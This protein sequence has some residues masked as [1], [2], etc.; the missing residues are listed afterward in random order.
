MISVGI[1]LYN[2][3][4]LLI[5][6]LVRSAIENG[7]TK[8]YL[9]DNFSKTKKIKIKSMYE[10]HSLGFNSG[11]G[12]GHNY[13]QNLSKKFH[14]Y[15]FV[16]NPDIVIISPDIFKK[17]SKELRINER[18][19]IVA[20]KLLYYSGKIQQSL[21]RFPT[22]I[23]LFTRK[24]FKKLYDKL[25]YDYDVTEIKYKKKVDSVSGAFFGITHSNFNKISGFDERYFM[26]LED[27]DICR[28]ASTYG[29]IIFLPNFEVYH[30]YEKGS[31]KSLHLLIIHII[32]AVKYF[33][34]WK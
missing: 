20:P 4:K 30:G 9:L 28:A 29:D 19:I 34:K 10:Y 25:N 16:V 31:S 1:V 2:Q 26:Y 7:A 32:S 33:L 23:S 12:K 5:G 22:M 8:V 14:T 3:P 15:H 13:L 21:R 11:F 6:R 24:F 27:I 18:S 17:L